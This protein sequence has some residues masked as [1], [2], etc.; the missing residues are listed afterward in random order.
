MYVAIINFPP[1][2]PGK[3][4]EFREWFEWANREF[5]GFK[6]FVRRRLLAP[7]KGGNYAAFV[8]FEDRDAYS[9]IQTSPTHGEAGRRVAPLLDGNPAPNFYEV[10]AG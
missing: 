1:V 4:A 6:G 10:M 3:D 2:K 7:E 5:A 8:E 9:A